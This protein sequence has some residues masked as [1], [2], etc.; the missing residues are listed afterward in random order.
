MS[1]LAEIQEA[2]AKLSADEQKTLLKWL[3]SNSELQANPED[4]QS[5]ESS[6]TAFRSVKD[7]DASI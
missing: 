6:D 5:L 3:L 2:I 7:M 4:E 1:T